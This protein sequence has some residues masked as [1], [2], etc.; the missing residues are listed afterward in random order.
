[1]E[2]LRGFPEPPLKPHNDG[3]EAFAHIAVN[4]AASRRQW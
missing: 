4:L 1:V 2:G 3:P